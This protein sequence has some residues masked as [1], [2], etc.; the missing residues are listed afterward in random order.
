LTPSKALVCPDCGEELHLT[1][2]VQTNS[3]PGHTFVTIAFIC[4][5]CAARPELTIWQSPSLEALATW[6]YSQ[7]RKE[8][9]A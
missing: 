3:R 8:E 6:E 1:G 9:D 2:S 5:V 7:L 4:Y